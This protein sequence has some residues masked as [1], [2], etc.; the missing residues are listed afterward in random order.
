LASASSRKIGGRGARRPPAGYLGCVPAMTAGVAA[1]VCY[2]FW[3]NGVFARGGPLRPYSLAECRVLVGDLMD[4]YFPW[5]LKDD[6]PDG[7]PLRVEMHL[8]VDH[9]AHVPPHA[10]FVAFRG[11]GNV[12]RGADEAEAGAAAGQGGEPAGQGRAVP[13]SWEREVWKAPAGRSDG[14]ALFR[15]LPEAVIRN[16]NVVPV[17]VR[18]ARAGLAR[19]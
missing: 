7:V 18:R 16:G 8:D 2:S 3:R 9:G 17:K 1:Q 15:R 14:Q 10:A 6:F 4:G 5:E 11:A 12:L 19:L 13:G